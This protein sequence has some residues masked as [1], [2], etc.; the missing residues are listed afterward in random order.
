M[1]WKEFLKPEWK[2][3]LIFGIIIFM[4]LIFI[5]IPVSMETQCMAI[6]YPTGCPVYISVVPLNQ[7]LECKKLEELKCGQFIAYE[8]FILELVII[9][10]LSC[11]IVWVNDKMKKKIC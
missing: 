9:Y 10:L 1:N 7:F 5:G 8:Y 3:F 11:L 4:I 6:G 2:K